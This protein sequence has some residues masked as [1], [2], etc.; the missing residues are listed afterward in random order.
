MSSTDD[1]YRS[2]FKCRHLMGKLGRWVG[3][4]EQFMLAICYLNS[5]DYS[6]QRRHRVQASLRQRITILPCLVRPDCP[7]CL[8]R[9]SLPLYLDLPQGSCSFVHSV[10]TLKFYQHQS[11]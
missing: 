3:P 1:N 6:W 4:T 2:D 11:A 5:E 7:F 9:C 10:S 8:P